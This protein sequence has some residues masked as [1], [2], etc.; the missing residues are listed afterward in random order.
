MKKPKH[1]LLWI[2]LVAGFGTGCQSFNLTSEDFAKQQRGGVADP[3]TG[4]T[5]GAVGS[6][7]CLGAAIGA[8]VAGVK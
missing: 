3:E 6:A 4:A 5:V 7:A 1:L 8:A 2:V